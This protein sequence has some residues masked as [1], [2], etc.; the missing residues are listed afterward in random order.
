MKNK[1]FTLIE[2]LAVIV[3]L[4]II[5]LIATP[6]ILG[7]INDARESAKLNSAQYILDG[8]S[9]AYAVSYTKS[10]DNKASGEVP[11]ID[12][13]LEEITF[14]NATAS[15]QGT[16][17]FKVESKDGVICNFAIDGS[18]MLSSDD[19]GLTGKI[20]IV[21]IGQVVTGG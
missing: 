10:Y 21:T 2:L 17:S 6:V 8:V 1:G 13:M 9:K 4:A 16:D 12:N 5:A 11:S 18:G 3:I 15:K 14:N 20:N 7:I 19:C